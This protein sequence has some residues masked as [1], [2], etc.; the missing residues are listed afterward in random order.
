M[1]DLIDT[2][3][4]YLRTILDLEEESIVPLR[5]RISERLGHSGPT[6]SQT[7]ARMERDGLVVVSGDRHLELTING[8]RKAVHVMRK[9]RLA[10]R[11]LSDVIGL[12]WEFVHD[13]ACRWEHV[14]SEQVERKILEMLG[15]PTESPYGN[16]IPGLDELGDSPAVAFMA[17]VTNLVEVVAGSTTPVTAVIRRLGEPVQFDPELL[18]QLKNAGVMPGNSGVFSALGS[19]VLVEVAGFDEGLELPNEVASHIFVTTPI[20]GL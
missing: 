8:R 11:L 5:A 7:V 13:E 2:T 14:M 17:G 18:A 19:Y 20:A 12:E 10:E 15:H 9:H 16:P 4:M 3:E 6:V 1:T